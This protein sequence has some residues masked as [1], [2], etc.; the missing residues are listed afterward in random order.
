MK[1]IE[2]CCFTLTIVDSCLI[3]KIQ[4]HLVMPFKSQSRFC[5]LQTQDLVWHV[6]VPSVFPRNCQLDPEASSGSD[7]VPLCTFLRQSGFHYWKIFN[8][9]SR[10]DWIPIH[11]MKKQHTAC[12]IFKLL[13]F[14]MQKSIYAIWTVLYNYYNF[15]IINLI[16]NSKNYTFDFAVEIN[17]INIITRVFMCNCWLCVYGFM[18]QWE[19][20]LKCSLNTH[21]T[22]W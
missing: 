10:W 19:Y 12:E 1:K 14:I 8:F 17:T 13:S 20:L 7:S 22:V 11:N 15:E 21:L 3:K 5:W 2:N 4:A 9:S 6:P 18:T 16:Y